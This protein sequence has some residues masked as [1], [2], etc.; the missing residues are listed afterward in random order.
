MSSF[1]QAAVAWLQ[2]IHGRSAVLGSVHIVLGDYVRV[3]PTC[4]YGPEQDIEVGFRDADND[5]RWT[6]IDLDAKSLPQLLREL[7]EAASNPG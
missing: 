7:T 3:C 2:R 5:G 1:D 6:E 4:D